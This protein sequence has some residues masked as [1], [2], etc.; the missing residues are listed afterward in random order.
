M[1]TS[2]TLFAPSIMLRLL[3]RFLQCVWIYSRLLMQVFDTCKPYDI[4]L[5]KL[6]ASSSPLT[7]FPFP[8]LNRF[9]V[10]WA[11][12]A[13]KNELFIASNGYSFGGGSGVKFLAK[14]ENPAILGMSCPLRGLFKGSRRENRTWRGLERFIGTE[15]WPKTWEGCAFLAF[16][17]IGFGTGSGGLTGPFLGC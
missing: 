7:R 2:K 13:L 17:G 5:F 12:L 4:L 1:Q 14:M 6:F 3:W 10:F 15:N 8:L 9:L 16:W 11:F